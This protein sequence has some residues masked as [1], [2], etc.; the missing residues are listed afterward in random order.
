MLNIIHGTTIKKLISILKEGYI[1]TDSSKPKGRIFTQLMYENMP[2]EEI[3]YSC[4]FNN[5]IVLSDSLLKDKKFEGYL[6]VGGFEGKPDIIGNGRLKRLPR[7]HD[8]K[9][10]INKNITSSLFSKDLERLKYVNSHEVI[11]YNNIDL[12]KYCEAIVFYTDSKD[13]NYEIIKKLTDKLNIKLVV[14][15]EHGLNNML[16]SI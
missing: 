5:C 14:N 16:E 13:K 12:S 3:Q 8:F 1:R 11:F 15:P 7:L 4:W 10:K 6:G 9:E 2:E